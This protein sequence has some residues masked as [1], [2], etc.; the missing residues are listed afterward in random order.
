MKLTVLGIGSAT[1]VLDRNPTAHLLT[2]EHESILIDCGEGTQYQILKYKLKPSKIRYIFISHLH[3]DHYLGLIGLVSSMNLGRRT[4]DLHIFGPRGLAEIL[5]LQFQCSNTFLHFKIHF[6]ENDTEKAQQIWQTDLL[7]IESIPLS[8]RIPCCGFLF[9]EKPQKRKIIKELLPQG[10]SIEQLKGLKEGNDICD[11]EGK[12]LYKNDAL[13]KPAD[14]PRSYAFCSDTIYKP[15]IVEQI[16]GVDW[17]YHE[18]TYLH[19]LVKQAHERYHTTALEAAQIAQ[20][21]GVKTLLLGHFSS[22]YGSLQEFQTEA[23]QVFGNVVLAEEG[24]TY[25]IKSTKTTNAG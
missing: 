17:L 13:T 9:R 18:A 23:Q 25:E 24:K 8:H 7:T 1:P 12:V 11:I 21:A 5:T 20:Q 6:H 15:D 4:D 16:S 22:R 19:N 3:G 14:T 2:T 10:L